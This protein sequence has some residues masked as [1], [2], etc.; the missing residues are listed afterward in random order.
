MPYVVQKDWQIDQVQQAIQLIRTR[1]LA[2]IEK[3]W[4][5]PVD[6]LCGVLR[7]LVVADDGKKLVCCDF[8]AIEAVVQA[9]L[10]RCQWRID[11]FNTPNACIYT[12]SASKITGKPME[13]Y[14]TYKAEHGA[15][16]EDRKK[17]GKI[18]ELASGYAGWLGAWKNFG[19]D[20]Y[21]NDQEIKGH[22]LKWRAESPEIVEMWG[23]QYRWCGPGKWDFTPDVHGLEGMAINAIRNPGKEFSHLGITYFVHQDVLY[24]RLPSGRCLH[25]HKPRLATARDPLNRGPAVKITFEGWNSNPN[26][27]KVGWIR[28]ETYGGRLF[29]NVVQAVAR[30][31]QAEAM[32]RVE[33]AGYPI[34]LHTHDEIC[35]EVNDDDVK[36]IEEMTELMIVR[37]EWADWWPINAA[38]WEGYRYRKD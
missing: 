23:G 32:L 20:K 18:A 34:I 7:G 3:V 4:G 9:C 27:G 21:F 16:H 37:P 6:L 5:D 2:Q 35:C 29:E 15:H 26:K 25:Y 38:G 17:I 31:I 30:D 28:M 11:V 1:D 13:F 10:A 22:I 12:Q 8:S 36:G 24:C 19:A 14:E 33:N